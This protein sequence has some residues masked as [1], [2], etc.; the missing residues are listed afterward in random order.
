MDIFKQFEKALATLNTIENQEKELWDKQSEYDAKIQFWL[1][2]LENQKIN[3]KQSYRIMRELKIL[4]TKRR[5]VKNNLD[6]IR[7]FHDTEDKLKG[8]ENRS[9]LLGQLRKLKNRQDNWIYSNDCY[10][11]EEIEKILN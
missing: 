4:R 9:M 10:S 8:C 6:M 1:H 11:N 5:E 7:S 2:Y 3:T